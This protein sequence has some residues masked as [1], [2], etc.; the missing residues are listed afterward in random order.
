MNL[1]LMTTHFNTGGITSYLLTLSKQLIK[2][3]HRIY[4]MSSGGNMVHEFE[5]I[6]GSHIFLNIRTKSILSPKLPG[7]AM[8]VRREIREKKIDII[9]AHTRVT[10]FLSA[11]AGRMTGVPCVTTCH[12]FFRA[13]WFRKAVPFWGQKV[14]AISH[15]VA[16]HLEKDFGLTSERIRVVQNGIDLD[17]FKPAEEAWR[18]AKREEFGCRGRMTAGI[19]ARLSDVK[20][21]S[22][23]IDAVS[24][25]RADIPDIKL[26]IVGEGKQEGRLKEQVRSLG[27]QEYVEFFPVLNH[28]AEFLRVFDCFVLPSLQEGL[29]LSVMEAQAAGLAVIASNVGGIP[30][31]IKDGET[32]LLVEPGNSRQ[33]SEALKRVLTDKGLACRLGREARQKAVREYGADK[34]AEKILNVY[35]E[36]KVSAG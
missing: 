8:R 14:I 19:I 35:A 21:H 30:S 33:L 20:G 15:Q 5:D 1:L 36:C 11:A 28:T 16:S 18:T 22:V 12:G 25:L 4:L 9:H 7:A 17:Q 27:L 2:Q 13:R 23:L 34:M 32:G 24:R 31:L 26:L 6:G 29:G 10:Q 3:G